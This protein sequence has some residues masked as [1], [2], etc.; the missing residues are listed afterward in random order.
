VNIVVCVKTVPNTTLPVEF[1]TKEGTFLDDEWNYILNPHDEVALEQAL[2]LQDKHGGTITVITVNTPGSE[3]ILRKCLAMGADKMIRVEP[4]NLSLYDSL[5]IAK[6]LSQVISQIPYDVILCGDQSADRNCGEV[7]SMLA[8]LLHL[9]VITSVIK[10]DIDTKTGSVTVSRKLE[11]GARER[12]RCSLPAL[13]TT[14]LL[15]NEPRYPTLPGRIQAEKQEIQVID[16]NSLEHTPGA[17]LDVQFTRLVSVNRPPPKRIFIPSGDISP[18]ERIRLLT[19]R[20][21]NKSNSG[22]IIEGNPEEIAKKVLTFLKDKHLI[23]E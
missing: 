5:T 6:I 21:T 12:A 20:T 7:G 11:K 9:P 14:D 10:M 2:N 19:Q 8:E 23:P 4:H 16:I 22:N 17:V 18:A 1:N 15:L 3:D 13:F